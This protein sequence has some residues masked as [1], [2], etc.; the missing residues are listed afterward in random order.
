MFV[1]YQMI[2]VI[3]VQTTETFKAKLLP[4]HLMVLDICTE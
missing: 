3:V 2:Q 4:L 1:L